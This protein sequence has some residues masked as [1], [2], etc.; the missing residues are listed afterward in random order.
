MF[1]DLK[2]WELSNNKQKIEAKS[3]RGAK[4]TPMH[5]HAKTTIGKEPENVI[6]YCGANDIRKDADPEK[7]E[8]DITNLSKS[9]GEESGNNVIKSSLVQRKG[10]LNAKVININNVT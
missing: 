3:F 9:V 10:Y 4:M 6:I 8:G 2:G 5:W 7:I 1:K